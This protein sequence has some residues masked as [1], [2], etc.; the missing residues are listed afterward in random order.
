MQKNSIYAAQTCQINTTK[1][2][3]IIPIKKLNRK[4]NQILCPNVN[5]FT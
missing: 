1:I 4:T 3:K 5:A 2:K